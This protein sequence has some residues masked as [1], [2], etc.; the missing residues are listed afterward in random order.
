MQKIILDT[1]VII[2]SLIQKNYPYL[3]VE[4]CIESNVKVCLSTALLEEYLEVLARP[5]FSKFPDFKSNADFLIARLSEISEVY[6]P[7]SKIDIIEDEPDNRI[8][9]LA[10]ISEADFIITGNTNDFT[11]NTFGKSKVVSPKEYWEKYK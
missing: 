11:M 10:K 3:I 7:K 9:E 4:Y 6:E 8:L 2:S 1:N 5:K